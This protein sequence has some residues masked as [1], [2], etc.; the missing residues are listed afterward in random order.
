MWA[1]AEWSLK[2]E[3]EIR[4]SDILL[5]F[6]NVCEKEEEW[7]KGIGSEKESGIGCFGNSKFLT[8]I[9]LG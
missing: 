1:G 8:E 6:P 5:S 4:S 7:E 2:L 3:G 9:I